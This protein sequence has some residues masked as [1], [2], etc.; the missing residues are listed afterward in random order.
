MAAAIPQAPA[1]AEAGHILTEAELRRRERNN[2]LAAL[3][4]AG[5][6]IHGPGGAAELLGLKPTTLV[7]RI[8]KLGIQR[9]PQDKIPQFSGEM[10]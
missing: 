7:S 5:W 6:K 9:Q 3:F 4:R 8:K 2:V 1:P 10:R